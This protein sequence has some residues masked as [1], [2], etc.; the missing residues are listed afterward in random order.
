M[1]AWRPLSHSLHSFRAPHVRGAVL[2][3]DDADELEVLAHVLTDLR[4]RACQ[5]RVAGADELVVEQGTR[6]RGSVLSFI[7]NGG[8]IRLVATGGRHLLAYDF[9]TAGGLLLCAVLSLVC[10]AAAWFALDHDPGLTVFGLL[11]PLLWLYGANYVNSCVRVPGLLARLCETAPRRCA[12]A[13]ASRV[14]A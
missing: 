7:D 6:G 3:P 8:T 14:K 9:S 13:T 2:V 5:V 10:A 4:A 11:A 12:G 1:T